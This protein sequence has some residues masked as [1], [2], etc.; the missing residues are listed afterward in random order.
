VCELLGLFLV[1]SLR[2]L[3]HF[4]SVLSCSVMLVFILSYILL[5]FLIM[6]YKPN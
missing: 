1:P 4:S 2:L 5:C 6:P 3:D